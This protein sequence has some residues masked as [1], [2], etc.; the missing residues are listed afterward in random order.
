MAL[1]NQQLQER[2]QAIE[3]M[4][5]TIQVAL[6]NVPTKVQMKSL[7]NIRQAE[8][9]ELQRTVEELNSRLTSVESTL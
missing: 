1:T 6:N 9:E 3:A 8:I 4:L 7:V 5:N 2:V